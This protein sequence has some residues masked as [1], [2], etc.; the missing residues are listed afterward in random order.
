MKARL[1]KEYAGGGAQNMNS[2][3]KQAQKM[4]D[5]MS[6]K[7]GELAEQEFKATVGGGAVEVTM[8]GKRELKSVAIKPEVVDPEDI[9]MLQDLVVAAVNE[10]LRTVE[11]TTS[12]E[13][14]KI[15]G[16]LQLPGMM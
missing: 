6:E 9:D 7:Q 4:Q 14:D 16:G 15:T 12:V 1:P 5:L 13:M 2:M 10:V 3:L 8:S 11:E